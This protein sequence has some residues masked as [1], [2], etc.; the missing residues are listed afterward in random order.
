VSAHVALA[1]KQFLADKCISVLQHPLYSPDLTPCDLAPQTKSTLKGTQFQSV[2]VK[3]I[4]AD[5]VN[6]MSADD[7]QRCFE[8]WEIHMQ[9]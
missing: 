8:Q 2:E 3:S 9:W 4:M 7:L 1:V 6:R 5:L